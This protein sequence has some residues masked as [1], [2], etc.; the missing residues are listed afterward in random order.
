MDKR[1]Y[2]GNLPWSVTK[3]KLEE[4]FSPYGKIE[5]ALV[6]ANKY[7]G[8]SRGF[9][10]VTY[11][12]ESEAEKAIKEM[13]GKEVEGRKLVVKEARPPRGKEESIP[14]EEKEE[15][16]GGEKKEEPKKE[17]PKIKD[18]SSD[19]DEDEDFAGDESSDEDEDED[20]GDDEVEKR[21]SSY[22]SY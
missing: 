18:E 1:I 8:R 14:Q 13:Q 5:D 22:I 10:F 3:V 6:M 9:G 4:L 11:K 21:K 15:K 12:S 17:I 19:E 16:K 7:T 2:V 20:F